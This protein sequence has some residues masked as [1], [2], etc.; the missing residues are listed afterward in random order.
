MYG[1]VAF[2]VRIGFAAEKYDG[3]Q[4]LL[5]PHPLRIPKNFLPA[6]SRKK[7]DERRFSWAFLGEVKNT[8]RDTM[9]A[10]CERVQG[11]KFLHSTSGWDS[12]DSLRGAEY[13]EGARR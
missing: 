5:E 2:A 12:D 1:R 6:R 7:V 11:E 9:V 8:N 13:A 3:A 4:N 10:H